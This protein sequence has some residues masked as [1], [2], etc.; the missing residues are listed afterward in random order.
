VYVVLL[1]CNLCCI[2]VADTTEEHNEK[3]NPLFPNLTGD[4]DDIGVS[5]IESLCLSC[6]KQVQCAEICVLLLTVLR[7]FDVNLMVT[8][9][10]CH[11]VFCK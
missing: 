10:I 5:E 9:T 1:K 6:Y 3:M 4:I 8:F 7:S 2:S 11:Y